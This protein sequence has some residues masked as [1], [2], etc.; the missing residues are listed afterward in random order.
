ML[1]QLYS[2]VL[3]FIFSLNCFSQVSQDTCVDVFFKI[4]SFKL[5]TQQNNKLKSFISLCPKVTQIIG[6]TDTTGKANYNLTLSG[7]RALIVYDVIREYSDSP[8]EIVTYY[9]ESQ[10]LPELWMNR[11]VQIH[12]HK[13]ELQT[14]IANRSIKVGDT[15][16]KIDLDNLYFIPDKP[17]L[18]QE[19]VPYIEELAKQ[20]KASPGRVFQIVGHINYQS[21]FDSTH[22]RD[23]YELSKLRAKAVYEYLL[24]FGIPADRMSYKGVGNSQPVF[25]APKNDEEKRKNMRVQVIILR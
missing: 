7:Q 10:A 21:R 5:E 13:P 17:I 6:F 19:S 8:D 4:N 25:A 22:L 1:K 2:P 15:M 11:R 18:S 24:E 3:F 12:A 9:G 16:R 23:L 20:L 14:T